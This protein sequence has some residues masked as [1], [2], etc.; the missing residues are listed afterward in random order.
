MCLFQFWFPQCI[1][2]EV[3]LLGCLEVLFPVFK[4]MSI[5]VSTEAV[6]FCTPTNS[7]RRFL[8]PTP[9]P[10]FIVCRLFDDG[11]SDWHEMIP[12]C[13]FNLHFSNNERCWVSFHVFVSLLCV[14]LESCLFRSFAHC[15]IRLF[16]FLV[17][18]CMGCL[19]ILEINSLSVFF[20]CYYFLYS[21]GYLFT[22]LIVSFIVQMNSFYLTNI[23]W[24]NMGMWTTCRKSNYFINILVALCQFLRKY[25]IPWQEW[26][27]CPVNSLNNIFITNKIS[28][29]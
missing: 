16:V 9:F 7:V 20:V 23:T 6:P 22:L 13:G 3:W 15:L 26:V 17:L 2:W 12:H 21:E 25:F 28:N 5:L 14:F 11:H 24:S 18:S 10:A 8:L 19:Y 1:Y 29:T 27:H 4:E